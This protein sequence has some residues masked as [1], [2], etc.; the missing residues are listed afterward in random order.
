MTLARH[1]R[2]F[3]LGPSLFELT[4]LKLT[5]FGA[6]TLQAQKGKP[7]GAASGSSEGRPGCQTLLSKTTSADRREICCRFPPR[8]SARRLVSGIKVRLCQN[9]TDRWAASALYLR[10]DTNLRRRRGQSIKFKRPCDR[11]RPC[12]LEEGFMKNLCRKTHK[13]FM[14]I[15]NISAE[16]VPYGS[17]RIK[18][19]TQWS[20]LFSL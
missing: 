10:V 5:P 3:P 16:P 2:R 7:T 12:F 17:E 18:L 15:P 11:T 9:Q 19:H 14:Q 1:W 8:G 6:A 20:Q 13:I 4:R